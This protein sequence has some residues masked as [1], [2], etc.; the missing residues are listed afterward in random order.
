MDNDT[1]GLADA[2]F[3]FGSG[4]HAH[5]FLYPSLPP[6]AAAKASEAKRIRSAQNAV[7]LL[8]GRI[9]AHPATIRTEFT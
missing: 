9:C 5:R 4:C 7:I 2:A 3:S 8:S 6:E 1:D